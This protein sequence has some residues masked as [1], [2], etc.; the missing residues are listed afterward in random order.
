M[1]F[2]KSFSQVFLRDKKYIEKILNCLGQDCPVMVEI[3]PGSGV[4]THQL[5]KTCGRLYCIEKDAALARLLQGRFASETVTIINSD[6]LEFD[7]SSVS[8]EAVFVFGNV[9]FNI[10]NSL[11]RYLIQN[12]NSIKKAYL[13][14]Q[15][16]FADKL[17]ASDNTKQYGFLSCYIQYYAK[18][19]VL[20]DIPKRAFFPMPGV[21]ASF[22]ELDFYRTVPFGVSEE[23]FLFKL[24]KKAFALRRKKL[25][26]ALGGLRSREVI[27]DAFLSLGL[28]DSL[29]PENVTLGDYCR[30]A[31]LLIRKPK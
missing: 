26:N 19:S 29:R 1:K 27:R 4:I 16:E 15:K 9:P 31:D 11:I 28:K 5:I 24:I 8:P 30:L 23:D 10:S 21:N 25:V 22:L 17:A 2:K 12:R 3:G 20:F 18:V 13:T 14:F 7:I 6:I